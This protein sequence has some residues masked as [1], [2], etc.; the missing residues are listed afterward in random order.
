MDKSLLSGIVQECLLIIFGM[1]YPE[2][3]RLIMREILRETLKNSLKN[4]DNAFFLC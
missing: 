1:N 4:D 2:D 3:F